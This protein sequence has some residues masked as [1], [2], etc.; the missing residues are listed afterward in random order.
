MTND[1]ENQGV[2][3]ND[4][5]ETVRGP[6][7]SAPDAWK[8]IMKC[9]EI[10]DLLFD[11][12][13]RELGQARSALVREHLRKCPDCQA[14]SAEIQSTLDILG[15]ARSATG[16]P[17]HLSPK[18]RARIIRASMHPVLDWIERHALVSIIAAVIILA[19]LV[20]IMRMFRLPNA[21]PRAVGVTLSPSASLRRMRR[22]QRSTECGQKIA[23][24]SFWQS[25][26][27]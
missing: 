17:D 7:D 20:A 21:P 22:R 1:S 25:S 13:C 12:M 23:D 19:C 14:A 10:R 15:K 8:K 27:A 18:H 24:L 2:G 6:E 11:Y 16:V 3:R 5:P 9:D 4:E 26:L